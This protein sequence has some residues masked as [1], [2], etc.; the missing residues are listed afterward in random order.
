[1]R[2]I[3]HWRWHLDEIF[4]KIRGEA[5]H[6]WCEVDHEGELLEGYVAKKR[7]KAAALKF[8]RKAIERY[9]NPE[10]M[11]TDKCLSYHAVM[12]AIGNERRRET[13]RHLNN[14]V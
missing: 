2:P 9:R 1:M 7:D 3:S 10:V 8:L 6:L 14:R 11:V 13:G 12:K 5:H 4:V